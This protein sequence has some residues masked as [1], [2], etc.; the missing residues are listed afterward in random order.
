MKPILYS[1][2]VDRLAKVPPAKWADYDYEAKELREDIPGW[3]SGAQVGFFDNLVLELPDH[4]NVLVCGVYHG[5]DL[6]ILENKASLHGKPINLVGVDLFSNQPYDDWNEEQKKI[7]TWERG[8]GWPSPSMEKAKAI[9][10][11]AKLIT[12]NSSNFMRLTQTG[13]HAIYLDTAHDYENVKEEIK[14]SAN[15]LYPGGLL[16][17]DDYKQ[18]IPTYGVDRAVRELLPRHHVLFDRIW[19]AEASI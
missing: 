16:C 8:L 4:A 13:F 19:L 7:G 12:C 2:M 5:M 1:R 17:G 10:P 11:S 15:C 18:T 9:C 3:S 14:A 6:H